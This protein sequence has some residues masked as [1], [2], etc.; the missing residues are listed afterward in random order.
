MSRYSSPW[1]SGPPPLPPPRHIPHGPE[2]EDQSRPDI[3]GTW[4]ES[5]PTVMPS[6]SLYGSFPIRGRANTEQEIPSFTHY[7]SQS[8]ASSYDASLLSKLDSHREN[9][10]TLG[11]G[12]GLNWSEQLRLR[13]GRSVSQSR[14]PSFLTSLSSS[15]KDES[16]LGKTSNNHPPMSLSLPITQSRPGLSDNVPSI[17]DPGVYYQ[18]T[19]DQFN[20]QMTQGLQHGS[21]HAPPRFESEEFILTA[22]VIKNIPFAVKKEQLVALM[23]GMQ[24]P[25]PYAINYHIENGVFRGLA[26]ANFTDPEEARHVINAMNHME[27]Q[28]RK[29]RVEHKKL[30]PAE[31]RERIE[32]EKREKRGQLERASSLPRHNHSSSLNRVG[33][34]SDLSRRQ[35][36]V[37]RQ[38]P[39]PGIYSGYAG[40]NHSSTSI[41]SYGSNNSYSCSVR[42]ARGILDADSD[43]RFSGLERRSSNVDNLSSPSCLPPHGLPRRH[44]GDGIQNVKRAEDR[45]LE[46]Y[47]QTWERFCV[48]QLVAFLQICTLDDVHA[49]TQSPTLL[50]ER[51]RLYLKR[52]MSQEGNMDF[53]S[54]Q[55]SPRPGQPETQ[56]QLLRHHKS[57]FSQSRDSIRSYSSRTSHSSA[58]TASSFSSQISD[59]TLLNHVQQ[60]A[61]TLKDCLTK[62]QKKL[63]SLETESK[64]TQSNKGQKG[65]AAESAPLTTAIELLHSEEGH[66]GLLGFCKSSAP[67]LLEKMLIICKRICL[68]FSPNFIASLQLFTKI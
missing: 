55:A 26:F 52:M 38:S 53:L 59:G 62:I 41:R 37:S 7:S 3:A 49:L 42:S 22:I 8:A 67:W 47:H 33:S 40:S 65:S 32:R 60:E 27:L 39:V 61:K 12:G 19:F 5:G 15:G 25:V 29:L 28:G 2:K 30:L 17:L 18:M 66:L 68:Y 11:E 10:S 34:I 16:V 23:S 6:S 35:E 48:L 4:K 36:S 45:P 20:S 57:S 63:K 1:A 14:R 9:A 31:E 58:S 54:Y 43:N 21:P 13:A 56:L 50:G 46:R 44:S 64:G 51:F 24:L